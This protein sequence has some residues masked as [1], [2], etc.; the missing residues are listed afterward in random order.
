MYLKNFR[1]VEWFYLILDCVICVYRQSKFFRCY[2]KQTRWYVQYVLKKNASLQ[3][4][5]LNKVLN[6]FLLNGDKLMSE[7]DDCRLPVFRTDTHSNF[8]L[9][10]NVFHHHWFSLTNSCKYPSVIQ[11]FR[12]S[13]FSI[14]EVIF[15]SPC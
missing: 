13:K 15:Y 4:L 11:T 14:F 7:L 6:N 1:K 12:Y 8:P 9:I 3:K 2:S 10:W 5:R